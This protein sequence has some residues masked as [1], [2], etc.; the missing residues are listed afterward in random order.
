MNAELLKL[1]YLPTPRWTAAFVAAV[2]LI[3]GVVLLAVA[4][5]E[6][7][8][9]VSIPTTTV[10]LTT[11]IAAMIFGVWLATLEFSADTL[12]R[13][14]TAEPDRNRVLA[15]KLLVVVA[16]AVV[17]G[18]L[19]A[20]SAGCLA[21][22]AANR[23]GVE[24]DDGESRLGVGRDEGDARPCAAQRERCSRRGD[25]ELRAVHACSTRVASFSVPAAT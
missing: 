12:Q 21:H 1:R 22:L 20:A 7:D 24:I 6:P 13:T 23:H 19:V 2:V 5:R 3:V 9:Y 17:G 14:L 18:L 10:G 11:A 8:K 4:P 25:Q 15:H 16:I